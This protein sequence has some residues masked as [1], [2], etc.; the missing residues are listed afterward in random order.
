M[1]KFIDLNVNIVDLTIVDITIVVVT[2]IDVFI[3]DVPTVGP[4][5]SS[6]L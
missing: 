1:K 3:F 2:I 6:D 5:I 4:K